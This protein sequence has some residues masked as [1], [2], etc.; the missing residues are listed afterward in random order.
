MEVPIV[1]GLIGIMLSIIGGVWR[2][3]WQLSRCMTHEQ[4]E[5][6]CEKRWTAFIEKFDD[7]QRDTKEAQEVAQAFRSK[8]MNDVAALSTQ[9]KVGEAVQADRAKRR[10]RT[11]G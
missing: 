8:L 6:I 4:H 9:I 3:S 11:D 7:A 1:I 5:V 2:I 10:R